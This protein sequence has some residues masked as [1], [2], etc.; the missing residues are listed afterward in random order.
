MAVPTPIPIGLD[1]TR[2][3]MVACWPRKLSR[4]RQS[5][6][7]LVPQMSKARCLLFASL[8]GRSGRAAAREVAQG[9]RI[10]QHWGQL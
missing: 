2:F 9:S 7:A 10:P 5:Q 4:L 8:G 1:Q 3:P 6:W